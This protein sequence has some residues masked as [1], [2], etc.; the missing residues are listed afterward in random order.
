MLGLLRQLIQLSL[1]N[2]MIVR[3][4]RQLEECKQ[5]SKIAK[6]AVTTFSWLVVYLRLKRGDNLWSLY[7]L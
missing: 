4:N 7:G 6:S 5:Q 1:E 2:N 3:A